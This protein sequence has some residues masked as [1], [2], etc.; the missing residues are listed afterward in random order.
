MEFPFNVN[1]IFGEGNITLLDNR[2]IPYRRTSSNTTE[3]MHTVIDNMG[4]ASAKA[5]G[6]RAPI[7]SSSRIKL[8][9]HHL[10][11][12]K[13]AEAN[14]GL[15][16]V[17]GILKI[18]RKRLFVIDIHGNQTELEPLCIL[19]FYVHESCQRKGY[20][21]RLFEHMLRT[22]NVKAQHLAIDRPSPKFTSFLVKH[23]NLRVTI[24]QVNNFV[25]FEG[26]FRGQPESSYVR[27][28]S[29]FSAQDRKLSIPPTYE[30]ESSWASIASYQTSTGPE[31][32]V[33]KNVPLNNSSALQGAMVTGSALENKATTSSS[34]INDRQ[35]TISPGF[36][37][38]AK[39]YSRYGVG[40]TVS[41]ITNTPPPVPRS[42]K[43]GDS[44]GRVARQSPITGDGERGGSGINLKTRDNT[45]PP[46]FGRVSN[47]EFNS[48]LQTQTRDGHLKVSPAATVV[49]Q[50]IPAKSQSVTGSPAKMTTA[51]SQSPAKVNPGQDTKVNPSHQTEEK[52]SNI[53]SDGN[54]CLTASNQRPVM[55]SSWNVLGVPP[56]FASSN[57]NNPQYYNYGRNAHFT[58]N[59]FW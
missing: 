44:L 26:F 38:Q 46:P 3:N 13:E 58:T 24:P 27:K 25:I 32:D 57:T 9:D 6:L 20:G 29:R 59:K 45:P 23:Y 17:I 8:S 2:L 7:T 33:L 31:N 34:Q 47:F 36:G 40:S 18:G 11:I 39:N 54:Y 53:N 42:Q 21:K 12:M 49:T 10:Y 50:T 5:Q 51:A 28:R 19:D 1:H 4:R 43:S 55:D 16:S 48:H 14:N 22:E 56:R 35:G 41:P 30:R 52:N 15:G 37:A